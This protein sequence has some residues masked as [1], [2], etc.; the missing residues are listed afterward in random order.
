MPT[1]FVAVLLWRALALVCV[2]LGLIGIFL[3]GLPTVPFLLVAAWAGGRGWPRLEA[4][5]LAHP[6]HGPHIRRWRDHRAVPRRAKWFASATMV[7]ST[8]LIALSSAPLALKIGLPLLM[9]AVAWWLWRRP[10][11]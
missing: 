5:L 6:R 10:E 2:V 3:P 7:A 11:V 9:S 8:V 1:R 4:W